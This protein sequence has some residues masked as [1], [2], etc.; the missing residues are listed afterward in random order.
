VFVVVAG[1][2]SGEQQQLADVKILSAVDTCVASDSG[3]ISRSAGV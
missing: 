1:L 2:V 3:I